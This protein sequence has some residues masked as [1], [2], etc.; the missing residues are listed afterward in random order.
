MPSTVFVARS[1]VCSER[2]ASLSHPQQFQHGWQPLNI[3]STSL[4]LTPGGTT[5]NAGLASLMR[6]D[7]DLRR[8]ELHVSYFGAPRWWNCRSRRFPLSPMNVSAAKQRLTSCP[9][10]PSLRRKLASR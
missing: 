9:P 5:G 4:L 8:L 7:N 3:A 1:K 6:P 2:R 10:A